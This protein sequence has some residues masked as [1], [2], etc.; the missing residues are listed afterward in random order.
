MPTESNLLRDVPNMNSPLEIY[1]VVVIGA[2]PIGLA[3]ALGLR[4]RGIE[5]LLVI[6][7]TSAFRPAGQVIDLLP[8]GLK[9]LKH[10]DY[11]AYED[12][13]TKG[14]RLFNP[15]SSNNDDHAEQTQEP[16]PAKSVR[17][18]VQRNLQGQQVLS[19]S[20]N[21]DD[22]FKDYGEGR[23][24][25]AWYDLQ[26]TLRHLLPQERV[27]AN[28]R[29]INVVDEPD[30]GC[31]RVDYLSDARI[32]ANPYVNWEGGQQSE[33]MQPQN[34]EK[35]SQPLE[36][37]SIRARIVVAADGINSTVR[38]VLYKDSPYSAFARPE[39]SGFAAIGC[40]EII[41]IPNNL[42]TELDEKFFQD[43][44][45]VT[46]ANDEVSED[47][48]YLEDPRMMLFCRPGG[49]LGY[50]I[51]LPLPWDCFQGKSASSLI[52]LAVQELEKA[53]FPDVLKQ[54]VRISSP[55][56][57]LQRPYYIHRATLS[58]AIQLPPTASPHADSRSVTIQPAWS[59][60]RVVLVGDAAHGMPPF[61]AQGA[62]QGLED[63]LAVATLIAKIA[64][65]NNWDD[66]SAIAR[67]FEKYEQLR[68]PLMIRVQ[69]AT[70]KR[71]PYNA[72]KERQE[73]NQQLYCRNFDQVIEAL[74]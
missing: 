35:N 55:A 51:H 20:L 10:L 4:Q 39:Y 70:L 19:I 61:M 74:L 8:N 6:D 13:K 66:T 34:S 45:I 28:H 25:I 52:D 26:T 40:R 33:E 68:R 49:Q 60:G 63:A 44:P 12:V 18:W 47:S 2:G 23:A 16:R 72:E 29:C 3:T 69:Q 54:L 14:N 24:S 48:V 59:V 73:Y 67:S 71:I 42:L 41:D 36:I 22:W 30:L 43:S 9:A 31:V 38:K 1:D 53:H 17:R 58:D 50:L 37:K 32:E 27:K 15:K 62:N 64:E 65:G 46:I 7:Q 5:N 56:N 57:M 11:E 21:F